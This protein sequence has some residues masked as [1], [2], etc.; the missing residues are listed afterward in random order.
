MRS[1]NN[2]AI[3]IHGGAGEDSKFIREHIEE[4]EQGLAE[5]LQAGYEILE[6]GGTALD[7][8]EEAIK[9]MEDN[10]LFN[11]GKGAALTTSATV[12]MCASI[13]DGKTSRVGAAAIVKNVKNPIQLARVILEEDDEVYMGSDGAKKYAEDHKVQL[14]PDAYFITEHQ[15]ETLEEA[16]KKEGEKM[17]NIRRLH[18][19]VGAVAVDKN[20]NVAAG[21]STGGTENSRE[22][23]I[24][25]SSMI[26]VGTFADNNSCAVSATGD[27]EYLIKG[28]IAR[29]VAACVEYRRMNVKEA[30]RYIIHEKNKDTKGDMGVI[31]VSPDGEIALEF[32]SERMHRAWKTANGPAVVKIYKD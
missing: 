1:K 5:A 11:A 17:Q 10:P 2:I 29:D 9:S 18:G 12:E 27:G 21:T 15:Y 23:R 6:R 7:A 20:G 25:D 13:M 31:A 14:M 22:D 3:A 16:K 30:L 4:Y 8:V 19:T 26:G 32:N 24:G 28:V